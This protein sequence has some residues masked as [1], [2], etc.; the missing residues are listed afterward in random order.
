MLLTF[1]VG[2]LASAQDI[3]VSG[4]VKD[5]EGEPIPGA[6]VFVKSQP[7]SGIITDMDGHYEISLEQN[8]TLVFSFIGMKTVEINVENQREINVVL[9]EQLVNLDEVVAVGY[10]VQKKV[11]SPDLS[12]L[13]I[14]R[15]LKINLLPALTKHC[16]VV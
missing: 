2:H 4:V 12:H 13:L 3:N 9:E 8:Q 1:L 11:I 5:L 15:S 6:N 10:G 14:F 7:T 16:R